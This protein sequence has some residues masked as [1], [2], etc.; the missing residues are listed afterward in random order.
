MSVTYHCYSIIID[1]G[2]SAPG[3]G[4][5]VVGGLNS[6]DKPYIYQFM[7]TVQLP[8]SNRFDSQMQMHTGNQKYDASL[9]KEFQHH[10]KKEHHKNGV[11]DQ[12]KTINNEW[13]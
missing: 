3:N 1:Q 5:E 10:M 7:S 12:G 8:A 13:K 9:D 4:K 6:V 11:F 2:M